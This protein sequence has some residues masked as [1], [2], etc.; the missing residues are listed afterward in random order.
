MTETATE[1]SQET[2]DIEIKEVEAEIIKRDPN[3]PIV[4]GTR[5]N[6]LYFF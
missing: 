6:Q 2:K 1:G 4:Q 5:I 3:D